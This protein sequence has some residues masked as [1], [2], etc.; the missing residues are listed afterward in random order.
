M[1]NYQVYQVDAFTT[2]KFA[3]NPAGVVLAADTLTTTQMQQI[4]R[5]L[6]N[7]ETAF[8]CQPT[9]EHADLRVRFFTP[10]QEV[11]FCGHATIAA[12]YIHA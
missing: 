4:A 5:E 9:D 3:G 12:Q 11:P 1:A 8:I 7:S 2:T 10:T 6:N